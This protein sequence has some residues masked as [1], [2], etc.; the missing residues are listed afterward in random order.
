MPSRCSLGLEVSRP[1]RGPP[2]FLSKGRMSM[3]KSGLAVFIVFIVF[4]FIELY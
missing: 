3:T 4:R 2:C 1:G